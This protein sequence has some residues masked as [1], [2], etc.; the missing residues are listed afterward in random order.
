[1]GMF[2]NYDNLAKNYIPNNIINSKTCGK[3]Y[4]KLD[5]IAAS[6]PYEEYNAKGELVG[7][8]WRYGETLKLEFNIDGEVTVE[9]DAKVFYAAGETPEGQEGKLY[10]RAYNVVDNRSWTCKVVENNI[11]TWEEDSEFT[12]DTASTRSIYVSADD[13]LKDKSIE[14]SLYN[15]RHE[16][17]HT[18]VFKGTSRVILNITKEL[19]QKLLRGIY[20]CSLT[21]CSKDMNL[22][23][24][25]GTDCTLLVK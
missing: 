3:S 24:F 16:V 14:V 19:S 7:Y 2:L 15:F 8:F 25:T 23:I 12:Y 20:Y 1:M 5:P 18:E 13:Y 21:V 4:T 17:I 10:Q 6:K 22:P 11:C 9:N